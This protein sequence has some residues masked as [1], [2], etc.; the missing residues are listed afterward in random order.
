MTPAGHRYF[1]HSVSLRADE[2]SSRAQEKHNKIDIILRQGKW[3]HRCFAIDMIPWARTT[4]TK[5]NLEKFHVDDSRALRARSEDIQAKPLSEQVFN[6]TEDVWPVR[7]MTMSKMRSSRWILIQFA[8]MIHFNTRTF[9]LY[10]F[11]LCFFSSKAKSDEFQWNWTFDV[12]GEPTLSP[13]STWNKNC[14]KK[15]KFSNDTDVAAD[16]ISRTSTRH[17][18]EVFREISKKT[19]VFGKEREWKREMKK[20]HS[21]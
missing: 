4:D 2:L 10:T 15:D 3:Q 14:K 13:G 17:Y 20:F 7:P 11:Y 12:G 18:I 16:L 19:I 21:F 1:S 5:K 6:T 8:C 9:L